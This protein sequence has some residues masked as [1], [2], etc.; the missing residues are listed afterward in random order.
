V[1]GGLSKRKGSNLRYTENG[2]TLE[3]TCKE[4]SV[5]KWTDSRFPAISGENHEKENF[6]LLKSKRAL[7]RGEGRAFSRGARNCQL[8]WKGGRVAMGS[9]FNGGGK[10][11]SWDRCFWAQGSF[12]VGCRPPLNDKEKN[13]RM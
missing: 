6:P 9:T 8:P 4:G 13:G 11:C 2:R 7:A 1:V 10:F 3:K 5:E 12:S